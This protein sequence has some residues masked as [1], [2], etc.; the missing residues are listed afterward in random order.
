MEL[1][2]CDHDLRTPQSGVATARVTSL[3]AAWFTTWFA[4]DVAFVVAARFA[5]HVTI[6]D[7]VIISS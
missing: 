4:N 5:I 2:Q 6:S 1:R 3:V 7:A